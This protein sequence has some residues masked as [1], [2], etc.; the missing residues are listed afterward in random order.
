MREASGF[1]TNF[2]SRL[3]DLL[4]PPKC[5]LCGDLGPSAICETC[6]GGFVPAPRELAPGRGA[7][8]FQTSLFVY[9]GRA[10]QAVRRLKYSRATS[11][12]RPLADLMREGIE[13]RGLLDSDLF[14]PVPIHWTR[15]CFRGFNQAEL[16][17]EALPAERVRRTGLLRQRATRPQ[18]GLNRDE[19]LRNLEGAFRAQGDLSGL[20]VLLIDDVVTTAGTALACAE[21]LKAAGAAEVG[22]VA[23]CGESATP[24]I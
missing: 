20:R 18:V 19:R 17:A 15:R 13:A 4:Y 24:T 1:W 10:A 3:L 8:D 5:A 7:L 6:R 2:S 12:A 23:L 21:V 14:V 11:L 16:L 9:E 22:I